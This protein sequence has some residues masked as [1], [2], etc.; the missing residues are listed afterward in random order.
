M[1][2]ILFLLCLLMLTGCGT[3]KEYSAQYLDVFDTYTTFQAYSDDKEGFDRISEGLHSQ[4]IR[5]NRL[6]DIYNDYE[7]ISNLKTVNDNAGVAPVVVDKELY[8]LV[9]AGISAYDETEGYINIAMG[10]VLKVWHNYRESALADPNN[11]LIPS[12]EELSEAAR[13]TDINNIILD[14]KNM[15]IYIKDKYASIDVGAIAKGYA[16]DRA[17]EYL[18]ENGVTAALIN[19]GGNVVGLNDDSKPSWKIGVQ[20]PIEGSS[21]Y[22]YKLDI[23][24]ASAV[25]SGNYQ[26]YYVYKDKI[27]HHIID[28]DTLMPSVNNKSVTVVS[29]SSLE[30]DIYSTYLF[31]LPY[32]KGKEIVKEKGLEAVWVDK[33]DKVIAKTKGGEYVR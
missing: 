11:A 29:P 7:G 6:F 15:S 33:D 3:K 19:L 27:Y 2:R 25:S 26:R 32:D 9:K 8:D 1:K 18:E 14:D 23:N 24:N 28:K 4:L 31:I 12:S 20:K 13:H 30:G 5:L 16:A 10:P 17:R 21:E 22:V